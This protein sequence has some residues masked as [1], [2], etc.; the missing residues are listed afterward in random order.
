LLRLIKAGKIDMRFLKTHSAP[1]GDIMKGYDIFGA[2]KDNC[3]KWI[4]KD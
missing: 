4:V 1:L 2:K 3:I